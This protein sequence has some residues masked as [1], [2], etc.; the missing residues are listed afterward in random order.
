MLICESLSKELCKNKR[1]KQLKY[2]FWFTT[3]KYDM[4]KVSNKT[5]VYVRNAFRLNNRNTKT[6]SITYFLCPYS[7]SGN[8]Q[9]KNQF[10]ANEPSFSP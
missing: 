5:A 4:F 2:I 8:T 6:T 7:Q 9:H 1:N 3:D 10:Q